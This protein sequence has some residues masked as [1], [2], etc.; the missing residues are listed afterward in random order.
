MKAFCED[1]DFDLDDSLFHPKDSFL[2]SNY[3]LSQD[4][5][6]VSLYQENPFPTLPFEDEIIKSPEPTDFLDESSG[7]LTLESH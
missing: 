7:K 4:T 2:N 3:Y 5:P 6:L 1:W